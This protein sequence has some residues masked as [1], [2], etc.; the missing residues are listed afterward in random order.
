MDFLVTAQKLLLVLIQTNKISNIWPFLIYQNGS[1]IWFNLL[2]SE[3][4][5]WSDYKSLLLI[6]YISI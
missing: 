4:L 2:V 1:F 6:I 5:E 3:I